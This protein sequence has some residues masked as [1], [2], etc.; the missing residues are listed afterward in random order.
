MSWRNE[1]DL[2]S[3]EFT[4]GYCGNKVASVK[5]FVNENNGDYLVYSCPHCQKPTFFIRRVVGDTQTPGPIPGNRVQNIP[6]DLESI[7]DEARKCVSVGAYTSA[8]LACRKLLMNVAVNEG[9]VEGKTFIAYIEYLSSK[10]YVPPNGKGW[11]DH[12]RVKGNE[13]NHEIKLMTLGDAIEL[14]TFS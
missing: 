6:P 11:V 3:R 2:T 9:D 13:A 12:I 5:G 4:C 10:G 7:Y 1:L 8:V 14:I